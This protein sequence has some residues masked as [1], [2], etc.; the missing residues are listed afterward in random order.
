M[1]E[2]MPAGFPPL[3]LGLQRALCALSIERPDKVADALAALYH[4]MWADLRPVHRPEVAVEVLAKVLGSG[5]LVQALFDKGGG[6]EAKGLLLKNTDQAFQ[7][8]A[9][10]LPWF[11]GKWIRRFE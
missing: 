3:T 4:A 8:G 1:A 2:E 11:V 10:G 7:D 5:E 9:F 6:A